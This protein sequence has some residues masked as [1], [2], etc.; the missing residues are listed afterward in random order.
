[1]K[2]FVLPRKKPFVTVLRGRI[3]LG[4]V[5]ENS[6]VNL[7]ATDPGLSLGYAGVMDLRLWMPH[8]T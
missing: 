1:M 7:I 8:G 4:S 3:E 6:L 5:A 2:L